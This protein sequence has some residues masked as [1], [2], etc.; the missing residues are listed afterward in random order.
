MITNQDLLEYSVLEAVLNPLIKS[1]KV[2]SVK[3][4]DEEKSSASDYF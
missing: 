3:E 1:K 4:M 2:L